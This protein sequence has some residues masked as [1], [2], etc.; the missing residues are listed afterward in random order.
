MCCVRVPLQPVRVGYCRGT[1]R[2]SHAYTHTGL[3]GHAYAYTH[4]RTGMQP[5]AD[6][7]IQGR[8]ALR[9]HEQSE[10]SERRRCLRL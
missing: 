7:H 9:L 8:F 10:R 5:D 6:T 4:N 1:A 2:Q 3:R